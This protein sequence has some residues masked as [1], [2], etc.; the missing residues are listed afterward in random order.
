MARAASLL[1][2]VVGLALVLVGLMGFALLGLDGTWTA[3]SEIPAGRTAVLLEPS[4]VS[5]LGPRV[6][7]RVEPADGAS[8]ADT[9]PT[10]LF[11]GRGRS[12]DLTAYAQDPKVSRVV[13]LDRS[14]DLDV[15][16]GPGPVV[17]PPTDGA[18]AAA[19]APTAT[20]L[21]AR[22][23]PPAAVDVWQQ[24]VSGPGT[25]ELTWRP[26]PG[27][28]SILIAGEQAVPLPALDIEV[29]WTNHT[30]L[31]MPSLALLL[32]VALIVA[33]FFVTGGLPEWTKQLW[34]SPVRLRAHASRLGSRAERRAA[35]PAGAVSPAPA[36]APPAPPAAP[37]AVR[38]AGPSREPSTRPSTAGSPGS[39]SD[40]VLMEAVP[41]TRRAARGRRRKPT[42]WERARSL[43][44][45][46]A[47]AGAGAARS[48]G[49]PEQPERRGATPEES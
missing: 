27:A 40:D 29:S 14:R 25:R 20:N 49:P 19:T 17:A 42:M 7:V 5:V 2:R 3:R 13:G 46:G 22:W 8:S 15:R 43:A 23:R 11:L 18:A 26:T 24:Q 10:E 41:T 9:A 33:G 28:Q 32:G 6:T 16:D 38:S 34:S 44:R 36:P 45:A 37:A 4:V 31:W 30:W 1:L 48:S 47:P 35:P 21:A 39:S 12:D